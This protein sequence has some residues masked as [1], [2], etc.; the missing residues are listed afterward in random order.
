[1]RVLF[2]KNKFP[3][4]LYY[5]Y[6]WWDKYFYSKYKKPCEASDDELDR[7]YLQRK[8]FL[9]ENFGELGFGEE[10]PV[11]DGKH[12][13]MFVKWGMDVIPYILG[14]KLQCQDAGGYYVHKMNEE[15]LRRLKPVD[16]A[17]TPFAEWIIKR[18]DLLVKRYGNAEF[19]MI[20]EASVNAASRIRGEEFY[21]DLYINKEF[22]KH[23]H[24]VVTETAIM[25]YKFFAREFALNDV[26]LA[27]CTIN[28]ISP[29]LYEDICLPND[30]YL[31]ENTMGLIKGKENY[32]TLHNCDLPADKYLDKYRNIPKVYRLEASFKTDIK[33]MKRKMPDAEFCAMI[34][35]MELVMNSPEQL[36][37][38]LITKLEDG[39][40]EFIV[41][42]IDPQTEIEKLQKIF[43]VIKECCEM[44]NYRP[45]FNVFPLNFD[46]IEWAFPQYKG[47]SI[48][49]IDN[50]KY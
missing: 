15:E 16:I 38:K 6:E 43:S 3:I 4:M 34:N 47:D 14:A 41:W 8:R 23:I 12:V 9:F 28:H 50:K 7:V 45:D 36:K 46:E 27:N 49:Q 39:A 19:G 33:A 30:I 2:V 25:A 5:M 40:G 31:V 11:M 29:E 48:Y 32:V 17:N 44:Y 1:M 22:A 21:L 18:K 42:S 13:N 24:D 26:T 20:L 35:P 37:E 10:Y